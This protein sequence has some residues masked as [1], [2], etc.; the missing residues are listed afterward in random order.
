MGIKNKKRIK[1][2]III[3]PITAVIIIIASVWIWHSFFGSISATKSKPSA[4]AEAEDG[5][6]VGCAI[7]SKGSGFSGAGFVTDFKTNGRLDVSLPVK[8]AGYYQVGVRFSNG[9][10]KNQAMTL[11]LNNTFSKRFSFGSLGETGKAWQTKYINMYLN[12]GTDT[13]ECSRSK[14]DGSVAFDYFYLLK[15]KNNGNICGSENAD[16]IGKCSFKQTKSGHNVDEYVTDFKAKGDRADFSFFTETQGTYRVLIK[17]RNQLDSKQVL[18]ASLNNKNQQLV[19]FKPS[20]SWNTKETTFNLNQGFNTLSFQY[21]EDNSNV[22][23]ENV[24][25]EPISSD[26]QMIIAPHPDDEALGFSGIIQNAL[27]NHK[28]VKVVLVTNGDLRGQNVGHR[29]INE[30][31]NAMES[32]G[33]K[34]D[35]IYFLGY[36]DHFISNMYDDKSSDFVVKRSWNYR[37]DVT[38]NDVTYG[39]TS[40]NNPFYAPDYHCLVTGDHAAYTRT[41]LQSDL[42]SIINKYMPSDI[43]TTN[44]YDTHPDH[45]AVYEFTIDAILDIKKNISQSYSPKLHSTIIHDSRKYPD[46]IIRNWPERYQT[47]NSFYSDPQSFTEPFGLFQYTT[48]NWDDV[49]RFKLNQKMMKNKHDAIDMYTSQMST[50]PFLFSFVKKDEFYWTDDF[51]NIA[52]L[53]TVTASSENTQRGEY[54]SNAVDGLADGSPGNPKFEWVANNSDTIGAWLRLDF[55]KDYKINKITLQDRRSLKDNITSGVL[56][57]S[58]G[59]SVSVKD[60]PE[61]GAPLTVNFPP[62]DITWANFTVTGV[63][64]ETDA[65]G[66]SE[67]RV[68]PVR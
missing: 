29:R 50:A 8:E 31:I 51:S 25:F 33:V 42:E 22:D 61:N 15:D 62:K 58:D 13:I 49:Q 45:H 11:M 40:P 17:Y 32:L 53:A 4:V 64:P 60:L 41:N 19:T 7:S 16:V 27:S 14:H 1:K 24:S 9:I 37:G 2:R 55:K 10:G 44:Y 59:S 39:N 47:F 30:T 43:Y 52:P 35:D 28:E 36:P 5:Y 68:F 26:V 54:A 56:S 48:L 20:S 23:I 65:A 18:K 6:R 63:S 46:H 66:L 38:Y 3:L 34:Q 12:S 67:I 21:F 57:F